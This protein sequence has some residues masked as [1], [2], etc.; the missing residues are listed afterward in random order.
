MFSFP[1]PKCV[2][3]CVCAPFEIQHVL[4]IEVCN[5]RRVQCRNRKQSAYV[6]WIRTQSRSYLKH[7]RLT[8]WKT[9]EPATSYVLGPP[10]NRM[11]SHRV[12][13]AHFREWMWEKMTNWVRDDPFPFDICEKMNKCDSDSVEFV[14]YT[15]FILSFREEFR[16][17]FEESLR[18]N[19]IKTLQILILRF[20]AIYIW[21]FFQVAAS[22]AKNEHQYQQRWSNKMVLKRTNPTTQEFLCDCDESE[23][24]FHKII[25]KKRKERSTVARIPCEWEA[26][27]CPT[28][29][30]WNSSAWMA[31]PSTFNTRSVRAGEKHDWD[32]A[33]IDKRTENF[34]M[35]SIP[36]TISNWFEHL[37]WCNFECAL[38]VCSLHYSPYSVCHHQT[39]R[40]DY[41]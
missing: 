11:H 31:L 36:L 23:S 2:R 41:Q 27:N 4:R 38:C 12:H 39:P 18:G 9:C 8:L 34:E 13:T 37:S 6:R 32:C 1:R 16:I 14:M 21:I 20:C 26:H 30:E 33:G 29:N 40:I 10:K 3:V 22:E 19:Q 15:I 28:W 25:K 35:K 5:E 17:H 7:T 24:V